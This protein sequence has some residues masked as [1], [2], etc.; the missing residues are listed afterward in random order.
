VNFTEF[1]NRFIIIYFNRCPSVK[2]SLKSEVEGAKPPPTALL[3]SMTEPISEIIALNGAL[4]TNGKIS[5]LKL[6]CGLN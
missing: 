5:S 4:P 6:T 3:D 1:L 2:K